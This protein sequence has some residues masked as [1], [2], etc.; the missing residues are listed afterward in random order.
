MATHGLVIRGDSVVD[1]TGGEKRTAD[2]AV[3]GT[4]IVEVGKVAGQGARAIDASGA[5]VTAGLVGIHT[6]DD[7]QIDQPS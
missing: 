1:G 7:G 3:D 6:H 4:T 2:V 5:L